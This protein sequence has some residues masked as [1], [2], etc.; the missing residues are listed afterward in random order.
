MK[1][2]IHPHAIERMKE[3]G[4]MK[5]EVL[6]TVQE[7]EAFQVKFGRIGF[8]RNFLFRGKWRGRMYKTKQLEVYG[9]KEEG[10]FVAITVLVKYF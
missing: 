2:R 4:A 7:G 1:V 6:E 5:K 10:D 8:R 9:V 3:R